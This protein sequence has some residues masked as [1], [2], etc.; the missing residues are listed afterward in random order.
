M[1]VQLLFRGG[2]FDW[3][4]ALPWNADALNADLALDTLFHAMAES[5]AVILETVQKVV[6]S[7]TE[8]DIETILYRQDVLRDCLEH[9][10]I[11]RELY[12]IATDAMDKEKKHYL[13]TLARYPHWVLRDAVEQMEMFGA[14]LSKLRSLADGHAHRFESEGWTALFNRLKHQLDDAYFRQVVDHLAQ[15]KLHGAMLLSAGLGED[16]KPANYVMHRSTVEKQSLWREIWEWFFPPK[17]T[18]NSFSIHPRDEAGARALERI[19]DEG[20]AFAAT[21]LAQSRDH[22]RDFFGALRSE[23]AFY[24]GCL[25]LHKLLVGKGEPV[26]FPIPKPARDWT[27]AFQGLYDASLALTIRQRAIGSDAD[28]GHRSLI[29]ITGANQGGKSTFLRSVGLAQLMMQSGMFVGAASFSG[30]ISRGLYTHYKREESAALESGKFDEELSRMSEIV[31]H[32]VPSAMVLFNESFA[33]TNEREGSEIAFQILS[34]LLDRGIRVVC[35][36]HLYELAHRFYEE[37]KGAGLFLQPDRRADGT[38]TFRII[39]GQPLPTS[40][41]SD[42]YQAIFSSDPGEGRPVAHAEP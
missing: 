1:K 15:L 4:E 12:D 31:N 14:L 11:V 26:C 22:I 3:S 36:T 39:E 23:M 5:D 42:L 8:G 29:I 25:N 2:D 19:R 38:R 9:S 20:I 24:I 37:S 17:P 40:F 6:L 30:S 18:A 10:S 41:G 34:G 21:T 32:L 33:A 16:N 13:G 35:V 7:A 27:L 28:A